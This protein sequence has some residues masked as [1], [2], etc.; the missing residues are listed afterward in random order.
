MLKLIAV[1]SRWGFRLALSFVA[2]L[3]LLSLTS[4]LPHWVQPAGEKAADLARVSDELAARQK[5]FDRDAQSRI[6]ATNAQIKKLSSAGADQL[7]KAKKDAYERR[8]IAVDEIMTEVD[9][10]MAALAGNSDKIIASYRAEY[11]DL[12]LAEH[13]IAII[14]LR[15]DSLKDDEGNEQQRATL[16]NKIDD[17]NTRHQ[18]YMAQVQKRKELV[19]AVKQEMR[20][21]LCQEVAVPLACA[22]VIEIRELDNN[23]SEAERKL[24]AAKRLLEAQKKTIEAYKKTALALVNE[25]KLVSDASG[26]LKAKSAEFGA[27]SARNSSTFTKSALEEYGWLALWIVVAGALL[28]IVHKLFTFLV[29]APFASR[30]RSVQILP[31]SSG[32]EAG[33]SQTSLDVPLDTETELLVRSG[34]QSVSS[35]IIG[36]DVIVLK[37]RMA[38]T[39]FAAGLVNMQRLRASRQDYVT[40]TAPDEEHAEVAL[41]NI[42]SGGAVVL[43]PRAL[44]GVLK[45]RSDTLRIDRPWR[46]NFLIS[47]VTFQFRY[48]VFH[49]PCTLIVQGQRGVRVE[50]AQK[51]R[52]INKRLTL[53]FDAGLSYGAARSP[54]F[55]P[56]L[57][58]S[59]SLFNDRFSG[60]GKYLFE[61][62]PSG[63][64]KGSLWGRGLKGLGDAALNAFGI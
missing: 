24:P 56:Y 18:I 42:P 64:G 40:V 4:K 43:Q 8:Q 32:M 13:I 52:M 58:G 22:K 54:S 9:I 17:H 21:P 48:V 63:S 62:R 11:I 53:G 15:S 59:E 30:A 31:R 51:G 5:D 2:V 38:F 41:I 3:A 33:A 37:K 6:D 50:D 25:T 23:I 16:N 35:D 19:K 14:E 10:T 45:R 60:N 47:W 44:V 39:C 49:G 29:I 46:F 12:P 20:N 61:Q 7:K 1:I 55:L 26:S 57:L 28:P 36:S 34:V 27:S